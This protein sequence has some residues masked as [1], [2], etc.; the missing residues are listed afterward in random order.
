M[1]APA[2]RSVSSIASDRC[3]RPAVAGLRNAEA[4]AALAGLAACPNVMLMASIDHLSA[5]LLWDKQTASRFNWLWHDVTTYE[6]Y[7]VET[8]GTVPL[9]IGRRQ[10]I[11]TPLSLRPRT[12]ARR[13][14]QN[15]GIRRGL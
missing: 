13:P 5:P 11:C 15:C 3:S 10:A 12:W 6:R 9:L 1:A 2:V 14:T 4:Q 7:S 8:E